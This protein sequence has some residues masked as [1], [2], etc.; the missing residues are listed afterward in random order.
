MIE[1]RQ[2]KWIVAADTTSNVA[3]VFLNEVQ[4][5]TNSGR[6]AVRQAGWKEGKQA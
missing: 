4:N 2:S 5:S 3:K 6:Q 1:Y